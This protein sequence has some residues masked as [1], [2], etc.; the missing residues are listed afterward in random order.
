MPTLRQLEYFVALADLKHFGRAAQ[1]CNVSQPSLSQQLRAL[2]LRLDVTLVERNQ[3]SVELTPIGRDIAERARRLLVGVKDIRETARRGADGIAG[4]FRFGVTPTL[5]P[6]LMS[7]VIS[8]LHAEQPGLRLYIREGIPDEQAQEL[9]RGQLDMMLGPQPIAGHDLVIE[10]LFRERLFLVAAPDHPLA[11]KSRLETTDLQ[12]YPVL[13]LH[14]THHLHRQVAGFCIDFGMTLLRDYEGTSLDSL[15]QMAA[16]GLALTILPDLYIRSEA[17][18]SEGVRVLE[19][20]GWCPTR[21]IAAAWRRN[22]AYEDAFRQIAE[23]A[24]VQARKLMG[25]DMPCSI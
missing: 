24:G 21:S 11:Q 20:E 15:R 23:Q 7:N 1:A 5:G 8:A 12:G 4:T 2:E 9:S 18:G 17:G 6:Y 3:T 25:Q 14:S 10:P 13:S 19:I 22:A 16:T